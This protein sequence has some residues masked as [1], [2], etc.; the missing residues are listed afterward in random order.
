MPVPVDGIG[1]VEVGA[2]SVRLRWPTGHPLA[3]LGLAWELLGWKKAR[4]S[5]G[6]SMY[7]A[8]FGRS[9]DAVEVIATGEA[10]GA[11]ASARLVLDWV[12]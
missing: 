9:M 6:E 12:G 7:S 4:L 11:E 1:G 8:E 5:I 3:G 2:S 10:A